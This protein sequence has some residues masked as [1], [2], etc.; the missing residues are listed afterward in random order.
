MEVAADHAG[1]EIVMLETGIEE[2]AAGEQAIVA[3]EAH[4][5]LLSDVPLELSHRIWPT[6]EAVV[7][8]GG[9]LDIAT[10]ELAVRY[11]RH[12]IDGHDGPVIVDLAALAFCDAGGLGALLRMAD[13]AQQAGCP[14]RLASPQPSV[15]KIMRITGLDRR[16][17]PLAGGG[18]PDS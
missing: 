4:D 6:R 11:V 17:P 18:R 1:D 13:Y 5:D 7:D 3:A 8:I 12:V 10:A 9:E 16:F 15:V 14:F 2:A